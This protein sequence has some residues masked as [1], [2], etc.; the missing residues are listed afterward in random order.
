[1]LTLDCGDLGDYV[2]RLEIGAQ[3]GEWP[4]D[5]DVADVVQQLLRPV[6]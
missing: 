3:R 2:G 5:E 4:V 6:L 1:M